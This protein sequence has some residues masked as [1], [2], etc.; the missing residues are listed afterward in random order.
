TAAELRRLTLELVA[1][2]RLPEVGQHDHPHQLVQ[3]SHAHHPVLLGD[4][5]VEH[6]EHR[7]DDA[8][9][10]ERRDLAR[11]RGPHTIRVQSRA[12]ALQHLRATLED[13]RTAAQRIDDQERGDPG[14]LVE[15]HQQLAQR[16]TDTL[17]PFATGAPALI[18]AAHTLT[19]TPK[20]LL[21]DRQETV[22]AI[23]E[24]VIE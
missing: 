8:L 1:R 6:A 5:C 16:R 18:R 12:Q 2:R 9:P 22:L 10:R 15:E 14:L 19:G 4:T 21:E 11:A 3:Q 23:L 7:T 17:T 13:P 24:H 20:R